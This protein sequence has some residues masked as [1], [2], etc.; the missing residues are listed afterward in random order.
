MNRLLTDA[1]VGNGASRRGQGDARHGVIGGLSGTIGANSLRPGASR[2]VAEMI[3][4]VAARFRAVKDAAG[5]LAALGPDGPSLTARPS[6][7]GWQGTSPGGDVRFK[8]R[9]RSTSCKVP[10]TSRAYSP[11]Q[12]ACSEA[13]SGVQL[14]Y[15]HPRSLR[16]STRLP[17]WLS[18]HLRSRL[19]G[20]SWNFDGDPT[21]IVMVRR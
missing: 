14:T 10:T 8:R 20:S 5:R 7:A 17:K 15:D 16:I 13:Q 12:R 21:G 11:I 4:L 6:S 19:P 2:A 9:P 1:A 18:G 3:S